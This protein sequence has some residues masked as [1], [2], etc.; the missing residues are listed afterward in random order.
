[1]TS[2]DLVA[3]CQTSGQKYRLDQVIIRAGQDQWTGLGTL[4]VSSRRFRLEV[5][6]DAG[7]SEP[8]MARGITGRSGFWEIRGL[9]DGQLGF[10]AHGLSHHRTLNFGGNSRMTLQI[11]TTSLEILPSGMDSLTDDEKSA[12]FDRVRSQAE[13]GVDAIAPAPAPT[14][15]D[16]ESETPKEPNAEARPVKVRFNAL[17][18]GFK[19]IFCDSETRITESNSFLGEGYRSVGDTCHGEVPGWKF[20]LIQRASDLEVH[21]RSRDGHVSQGVESDDSLFRAFLD[22][23]AFTHG[24]HTWPL[25]LQHRRDGKLVLDR[26]HVDTQT[27]RS[28]HAPFRESLVYHARLKDAQWKLQDCL[29]KA[30][31]FFAVESKFRDEITRLLYLLREAT[32]S[33]VAHSITLLAVCSLFESLIRAVYR[34]RVAPSV[35]ADTK[36]FEAIKEQVCKYLKDCGKAGHGIHYDRLNSILEHTEALSIRGQF[37]ELVSRMG[38]NADYWGKVYRLWTSSRNP[39]SHRITS[40]DRSEE[41]DRATLIAESRVAGAINGL[42]LKLVG[43]TGPAV[44]SAF[45]DMLVQIGPTTGGLPPQAGS[46]GP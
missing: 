40:S 35:E 18:K 39:A 44:G 43:Y 14:P 19:L 46:A 38:L 45:E 8:P 23:L 30:Y 7:Q 21:F 1:M 9:I 11:D 28:S 32:S 36:A 37:Q 42:V 17:I 20:G 16:K 6:L 4:D 41:T 2:Q 3:A 22:G 24:Q 26:I 5:T 10:V 15:N 25:W 31:L 12:L 33:D 29:E 34:H 13:N 27:T